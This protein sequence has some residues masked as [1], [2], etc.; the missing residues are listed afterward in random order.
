MIKF[1]ILGFIFGMA[2]TIGIYET[3][4]DRKGGKIQNLLSRKMSILLQESSMRIG[5][6]QK[7]LKRDLTEEEKDKILD[8]CYEYYK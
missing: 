6:R 8:E 1:I 2:L 5:E 3:I 4:A 7:I